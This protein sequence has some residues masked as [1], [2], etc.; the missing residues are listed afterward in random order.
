LN[1]SI[2]YKELPLTHQALYLSIRSRLPDFNPPPQNRNPIQTESQ[3]DLLDDVRLLGALLG[4]IICE[5]RGVVFYQFIEN[6]RRA[7][8]KAR[9]QDNLAGFEAFENILQTTMANLTSAEKL[10]W[11]EDAASAFRLFLTLT[12]IAEGYHQ[13]KIHHEE[14][15]PLYVMLEEL[16][17]ENMSLSEV[18]EALER[19]SVRLV[20]TAH[21]TTILRQTILT[22]QADL[23][24][25]L[26]DLHQPHLTRIKQLELMEKLS[27]KVETLWATQFSRWSKPNVID[28]VKQV[29]G[30]FDKTLYHQLPQLSQHLEEALSWIYPDQPLAQPLNPVVVLGSWVG[31]DM[32][33]NPFVTDSVFREALSVQFESILKHYAEDLKLLSQQ[34]SHSTKQVPPSAA[35][36]QAIETDLRLMQETHRDVSYYHD[37]IEREPHRLKLYLIAKKLLQ[38]AHNSTVS[39]FQ[40]KSR[41][42]YATPQEVIADLE[43]ILESYQQQQYARFVEKPL[44]NLILKVKTFGF[45]FATIDLREDIQNIRFTARSILT[46]AGVTLP[47]SPEAMMTLLSNEVLNTKTVSPRSLE[48]LIAFWQSDPVK[49]TS[50][51][52]LS[53]MLKA[54][55]HAH[56]T[57]GKGCCQRL[58][59]TMTSSASDLLY[60]LY[61]LKIFDLVYL[62][63]KQQLE[64]DL[65]ILP[66]F[67]TIDDL[68]RA[69]V[70]LKHAL[71][72]PAYQ[73]QISARHGQQVVMLG[74]SDSNK[75]GGYFASNWAAYQAQYKLLAVGSEFG[76]KLRFFH[77]RGGN[78]G[79]GGGPAHSAI[80]ALPQGSCYYGQEITEQGE[81]L[82]RYYNIPDFAETHLHNVFSAILKKNVMHTLS[83]QPAWLKIA[84]SLAT[85]S[86]QAYARLI[87]QDPD[88]MLYFDAA[89]PREVEL[90]QIG[91]RPAKR[92]QMKTIQDLRAIPWVFRWFQSRQI[93]PGWYGLGT[94][95]HEFYKESPETSLAQLKEMY[96][97]WPFFQSVLNNCQ[98]AL[99]QTDF[100]IARY[101]AQLVPQED[102]AHRII[103]ILQT[104]HALTEKMLA[105]ITGHALL[106]DPEDLPMKQSVRI[107]EPYLDPLNFIQ[108]KLLKQYRQNQDIPTASKEEAEQLIRAIISSIEGVA[109]GL[110]TTG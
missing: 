42:A 77:G 51:L 86:Y 12:G 110:G 38:T 109:T 81:V 68:N 67:E 78:I 18:L 14:A 101:Y 82:S 37:Q 61:L 59:I 33:G 22:H 62:N 72:N 80:W 21:P 87:H 63:E 43:Q 66:L 71:Q 49:Y 4:L 54:V 100:G 85:E 57:M 98:I 65:D 83:A 94:A 26:K 48:D 40:N 47:D 89:T 74:Y 13:S 60:A 34:L 90:V 27:E 36:L 2:S 104:E 30:Y 3:N 11:L 9:R 97:T 31:G 20:A 56:K 1:S 19:Q 58:I 93:I 7:S 53:Q 25:L 95:L 46:H 102:M 16:K 10:S 28:E 8:K 107:K 24:H 99:F 64:S 105:S 84:N 5:H 79:R 88:F 73:K 29:L 35:L 96:R 91:S 70:I 44:Q 69:D 75:D 32:D 92:R 41:F 15:H 76:L 108:V 103:E 6:L 106:G 52:R 23:Y 39:S 55:T 45:H 17:A 50:A